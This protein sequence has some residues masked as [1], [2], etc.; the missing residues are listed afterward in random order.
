MAWEFILYSTVKNENLEN[1]TCVNFN[2]PDLHP[3]WKGPQIYSCWSGE[4]PWLGVS[5]GVP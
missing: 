2:P 1:A 3:K 4:L 5:E